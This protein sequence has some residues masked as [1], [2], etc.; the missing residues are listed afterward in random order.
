MYFPLYNIPIIFQ[1]HI[2]MYF[3]CMSYTDNDGYMILNDW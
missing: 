2:P 3:P 1:Y